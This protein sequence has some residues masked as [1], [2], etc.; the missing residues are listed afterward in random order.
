MCDCG[1]GVPVVHRCDRRQANK[2]FSEIPAAAGLSQDGDVLR[3][4]A[5]VRILGHATVVG[6]AV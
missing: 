6:C 3:A 1:Y 4:V 2:I 5:G